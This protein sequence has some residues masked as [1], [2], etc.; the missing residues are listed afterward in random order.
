LHLIYKNFHFIIKNRLVNQNPEGRAQGVF[1]PV[2]CVLKRKQKEVDLKHI[3]SSVPSGI[4]QSKLLCGLWWFPNQMNRHARL[5]IRKD[6]TDGKK[7][8][9]S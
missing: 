3:L 1:L 5:W 8:R 7:D 4:C 2:K 6:G 9:K